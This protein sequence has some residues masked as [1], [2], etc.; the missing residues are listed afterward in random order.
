[1]LAQEMVWGSSGQGVA[2]GV[3]PP[4]PGSPGGERC[5]ILEGCPVFPLVQALLALALPSLCVA[6]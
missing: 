1:M 6:M 3:T 5:I 4:G 2:L